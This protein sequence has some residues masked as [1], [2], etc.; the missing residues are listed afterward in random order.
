VLRGATRD[1]FERARSDETKALARLL[2][3]AE[4]L[5]EARGTASPAVLGQIRESLEAAAISDEG[6]T[7]LA[8]GRF[9]GAI[10]R[11]GFDVVGE[12]APAAPAG[13]ARRGKKDDAR[14]E[15]Q[16]ALREAKTRLRDAERSAHR[17][18][19]DADRLRAD[20]A[21][22]AQE[23]EQAEAARDRVAAEVE[24]LEARLRRP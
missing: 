18:R 22:A 19:Q 4:R 3:E 13:P 17:A 9:T 14:R 24:E 23:A 2:D 8:R 20:A 7:L 16:G 21:A 12:L 11:T 15:A 10:A 6:R 1:V 5:L